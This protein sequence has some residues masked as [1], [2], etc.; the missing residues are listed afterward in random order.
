MVTLMSTTYYFTLFYNG[1]SSVM[2]RSTQRRY[3]RKIIW[4]KINAFI[5]KSLLVKF[6]NAFKSESDWARVLL[7]RSLWTLQTNPWLWLH[8]QYGSSFSAPVSPS[9]DSNLAPK[10]SPTPLHHLP[11]VDTALMSLSRKSVQ[12]KFCSTKADNEFFAN[13]LYTRSNQ[14]PCKGL[15]DLGSGKEPTQGIRN[16]YRYLFS[17]SYVCQTVIIRK[18][19]K[20][21]VLM[22]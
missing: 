19:Y 22:N 10:V 9:R 8:P 5:A 11:V 7:S 2:R 21:C 16:C 6:L 4:S 14:C 12:L 20:V 3:F 18:A 13:T 17:P 15:L 1:H